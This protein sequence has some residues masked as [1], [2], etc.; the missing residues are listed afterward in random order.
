MNLLLLHPEDRLD[1]TRWQISGRR[2][3]HLRRVR[4][5]LPGEQVPA[6]ECGGLLGPATLLEDDGDSMQFDFR[7]THPAPAPLPLTLVLALPRPKMLKR[8]LIDATSLGIKRI[9][10][11]NSHKVE[12]SFWKT[13]EL[14]QSLLHEKM[15]L[16]LEQAGDT[17][18]PELLL[19][20]RFRPVVE[21]ELRALSEQS[22]R[23][24]A[25]PGDYSP[26]PSG[27]SVPVTL[28]VGPEGGW[29]GYEVAM[30]QQCGFT[31]HSLGQRIL[32]VETAVPALTAH[33]MQLP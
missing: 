23:L 1:D 28:A 20:Q 10:L 6:G 12:K 29:T 33:I 27:L 8:I 24:L 3:E 4:A 2:A 32:R 7:G 19:R 25:H 13:P 31:C 26:L 16:G 14:K 9:V 11:L 5:L 30:L 18:M 15:L 22:Q 17:L 21:D